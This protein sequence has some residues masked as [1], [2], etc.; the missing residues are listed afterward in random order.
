MAFVCIPFHK[1]V[2]PQCWHYEFRKFGKHKNRVASNGTTPILNFNQIRPAVLNMNHTDR[3]TDRQTRAA[4]HE[5]VSYTSC[6]ECIKPY[7]SKMFLLFNIPHFCYL[8]GELRQSWIMAW[9][10]YGK[11][12]SRCFYFSIPAIAWSRRRKLQKA[13]CC[14]CRIQSWSDSRISAVGHKVK[15]PCESSF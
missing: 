15:D 11:K 5:I 8:A 3:Q 12:L 10:K 6:K 2:P 14:T 1:F 4:L 9:S 13:K 7:I